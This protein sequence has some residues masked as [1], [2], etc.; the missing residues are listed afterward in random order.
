MNK[1]PIIAGNWKMN[2]TPQEGNIF[3]DETQ[4]LVPDINGVTVIFFPSTT[5]LYSAKTNSPF[6]LGAQ[7]C[8]SETSGAYTGETSVVMLKDCEVDYALVGHSERRQIFK[9]SNDFLNKKIDTLL[10]NNIKP[11]L[12]IGETLNERESNNTELILENQ[13]REGL[14]GVKSLENCIIAYEPIWAI[15]TG[16]TANTEQ[17][18]NAHHHIKSVLKKIYPDSFNCHILYG[19]SVNSKNAKELIEIEGVDGFLIGGASL[20][21]ESFISIIKTV[22]NIMRKKS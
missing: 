10:S 7:N 18:K 8:H 16:K 21:L 2:K 20:A 13:L 22:E 17:I 15:G 12:C 6:Y 1:K 9:E 5:S 4:K 11:I 3:I 19:G 14:I